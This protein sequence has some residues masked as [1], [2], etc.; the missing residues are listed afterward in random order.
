MNVES[1]TSQ[2]KAARN[3]SASSPFSHLHD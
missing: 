3:N 2:Q 1:I